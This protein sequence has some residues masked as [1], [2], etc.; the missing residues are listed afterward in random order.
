MEL[1]MNHPRD[2]EECLM[3]MEMLHTIIALVHADDAIHQIILLTLVNFNKP[4]L[5]SRYGFSS[6][7]VRCWR[8][9]RWELKDSLGFSCG[10]EPTLWAIQSSHHS[11]VNQQEIVISLPWSALG[12]PDSYFRDAW[13]YTCSVCGRGNGFSFL[14]PWIWK[15]EPDWFKGTEQFFRRKKR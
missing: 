6:P 5:K 2:T 4:D 7:S 3:V 13:D 11:S 10:Q 1:E 14:S 8:S 15:L 9:F 12:I